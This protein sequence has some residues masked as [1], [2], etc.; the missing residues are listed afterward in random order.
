MIILLIVIFTA[1]MVFGFF[2]VKGP[3]QYIIGGLATILAFLSILGLIFHDNNHWGMKKVT[4]T[5]TMNIPVQMVTAIKVGDNTGNYVFTYKTAD[6]GKVGQH[7][8]PDTKNIV[9][10][11]KK[12]SKY[13]ETSDKTAEVVTTTVRWEWANNLAKTMFGVGGEAGE[14]YKQTNVVRVPK[15]TILVV[16]Q[17]EAKKLQAN[18]SKIAE[19][20]KASQ[21]AQVKALTEEHIKEALAQLPDGASDEQKEAVTQQVTEKV[22]AQVAEKM[23][24]AQNDPVAYAQAQVT[25]IKSFLEK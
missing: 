8:A 18:Q 25:A 13:E 12:T 14:L 19:S 11:T 6:D 2:F 20:A 17:E 24:A 16:N 7:F 1:L 15:G 3:A 21:E 9:E 22:Q 10:A 23:K 4:S 5:E